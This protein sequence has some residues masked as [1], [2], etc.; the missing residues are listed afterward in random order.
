MYDSLGSVGILS[1]AATAN[2]NYDVDVQG[3]IPTA[4][5]SDWMIAVTN[6]TRT[7]AKNSSCGYGATTIDLGA[8]GTQIMSTYPSNSYSSTSGTSM[9]TPHVAGAVALMYSLNCP[10]LIT[11]YKID[12]AGVAL[13]IKDSL[14]AAVDVIPSMSSGITLT[15][16][17][18]NLHKSVVA[19]QNYCILMDVDN[20][21]TTYDF[22]IQNVYPNPADN[23][24]NIVYNSYE[25][26]EISISN[27][28][29]QELKRIKGD[30][31]TKGIQHSR[32][33]VSDLNKGVYFI[34][35]HSAN[36]KSNTVKVIVY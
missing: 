30:A 3:D 33:D 6:T 20:V 5:A 29:G 14:L 25:A 9:A 7:D 36:K 18:L 28:L 10:I 13:I 11:N 24:L 23:T 8:P 1:A 31:T 22:E 34:S 17:R 16:G 26:I 32:L 35:I 21:T 12:P 19:M 15:G 4:C 2:A 27:V